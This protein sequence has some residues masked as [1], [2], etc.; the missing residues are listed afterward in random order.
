[1]RCVVVIIMAEVFPS[2]YYGDPADNIARFER[3][4]R[5]ETE[6][7]SGCCHRGEH[8]AW[9]KYDCSIDCTPGRRGFCRMWR[10]VEVA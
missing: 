4:D 3:R 1:M 2:W 7:C 8:L 10:E 9:D 6:G 5:R